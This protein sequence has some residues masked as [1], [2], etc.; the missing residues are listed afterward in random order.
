MRSSLRWDRIGGTLGDFLRA[1]PIITRPCPTLA[2]IAP[3][4]PSSLRRGRSSGRFSIPNRFESSDPGI[5][6]LLALGVLVFLPAGTLAYWQDWAFL[7]LFTVST[8]ETMH[9]QT[10]ISSG[11]YALVR[12]P[13]YVD[14]LILVV[15]TP[16]ALDSY[17]GLLFL[18]LDVPILMAR[19]LDEEKMLASDLDGYA[20]YRRKVRYRLVPGIW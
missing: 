5:C 13:M 6:G 1:A 8:I 16:L 4:A 2:H 15:G 17:W 10:V 19:I 20:Q 9:G 12:H 11:P 18:L 3:R 14:V 7:V